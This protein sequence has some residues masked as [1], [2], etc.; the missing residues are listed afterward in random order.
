[1][2]RPQWTS[3]H[4]AQ[5]FHF[6]DTDNLVRPMPAS[7]GVLFGLPVSHRPG[8]RH[9]SCRLPP[10]MPD[11]RSTSHLRFVPPD[12]R[13][14]TNTST[15]RCWR[16]TGPGWDPPTRRWMAC[17][18]CNT[19]QAFIPRWVILMKLA[20]AHRLFSTNPFLCIALGLSDVRQ[21]AIEAV[22]NMQV[23]FLCLLARVGQQPW[24]DD[25]P[26]Y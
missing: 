22:K 15:A 14:R 16:T 9:R 7:V 24:K 19:W 25:E 21:A 6:H 3:V 8:I 12:R 23:R 26:C 13:C 17:A 5:P 11:T 2:T 20:N 10:L 1:M 4:G 18:I